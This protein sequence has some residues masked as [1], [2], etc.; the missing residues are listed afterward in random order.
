[1]T[2][3]APSTPQ[4][5]ESITVTELAALAASVQLIDVREPFE[6]EIARIAG[7]TLIPL[8]TL[9]HSVDQVSTDLPVVV[10][11]HHDS[12]SRVAVRMLQQLGIEDVR[13]LEG[14]IDA[15]SREIDPTVPRY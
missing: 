8:G 6:V 14:G 11:C 10:H 13:W 1:M 9:Q 4:R 5:S 2:S 15:W 7:A 12:R 3:A